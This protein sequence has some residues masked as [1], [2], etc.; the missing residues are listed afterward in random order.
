M[1]ISINLGPKRVGSGGADGALR[2]PLSGAFPLDAGSVSPSPRRRSL[3]SRWGDGRGEVLFPPSEVSWGEGV[4]APAHCPL[5]LFF[6]MSACQL[7]SIWLFRPCHLLS[8]FCTAK[9]GC[10]KGTKCASRL[11][12]RKLVCGRP[13]DCKRPLIPAWTRSLPR[14]RPCGLRLGRIPFAASRAAKDSPGGGEGGRR[15]DEGETS[16]QQCLPHH[17][18]RAARMPDAT[19]L[20][21]RLGQIKIGS[22]PVCR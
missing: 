22:R 21:T 19:I 17:F 18:Y 11:L 16:R 2:R 7:F 20:H 6:S 15:P 10:Q 3:R 14:T 8:L 9:T 5:P 1:T 13:V 12:C 4:L